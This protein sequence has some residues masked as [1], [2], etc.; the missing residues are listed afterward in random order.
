MLSF[1]LSP[2][3]WITTC[4]P[5]ASASFTRFSIAPSGNISSEGN[6]KVFGASL[7]GSKKRAVVE[8]RLPSEKPLSPPTRSMSLPKAAR[9]PFRAKRSQSGSGENP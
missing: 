2:M 4:N 7:Y 9:T 6:P 3:A 8:P 5:V 1:A